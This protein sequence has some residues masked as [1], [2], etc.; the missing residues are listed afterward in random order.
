MLMVCFGVTVWNPAIPSPLLGLQAGGLNWGSD[1]TC[2]FKE[3]V[4]EIL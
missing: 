1:D 3:G 4:C 2:K